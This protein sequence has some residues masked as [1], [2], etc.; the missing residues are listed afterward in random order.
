MKTV[1]VTGGAGYIGS[2]TCKW[3]ASHGY[4]PV[5]VDNLSTGFS[6]SVQWGP[7]EVLDLRDTSALTDIFR[8]YS[9]AAVVHFAAFSAVGESVRDP[10]KY[11]DNNIGAT[12]SLVS[13]M[14]STDVNKIVFSS[15][16]AVYGLPDLMPIR[17]SSPRNPINPYG[18][19]KL[20]IENILEDLSASSDLSYVSLRYFNAAGAD[21]NGE[22]GERHDPE[23]HLIPLAIRAALGASPLSVFGNDFPTADGTAIRDYVHVNDLAS[24]HQL[25]IDYLLKGGGSIAL[26]LGTG[27]GYSVREILSAINEMGSKVPTIDAPRR[28]GDPAELVANSA[29]AESIIGW[30]PRV[31][32]LNY[33]LETALA[34]HRRNG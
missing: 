15:T 7:L 4:L 23:T 26:N 34:W 10:L 9:P 22:L 16:C 3:L 20:L 12:L 24:A 30:R 25:A 11:Y 21:P 8:R 31:S 1:I 28:D 5:T 6:E 33:I 29:L 18:R 17:E 19:S 27:R 13:A 32:S 14:R 2:H